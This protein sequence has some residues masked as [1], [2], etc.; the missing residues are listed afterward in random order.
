MSWREFL[1]KALSFYCAFFTGSVL[2]GYLRG[3]EL[4][5]PWIATLS[6]API[7]ALVL[8]SVISGDFRPK[9]AGEVEHG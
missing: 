1:E 7:V 4:D 8:R 9:H 2:Y 5:I 3:F 6:T